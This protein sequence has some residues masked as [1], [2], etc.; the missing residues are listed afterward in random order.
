MS[1]A[2]CVDLGF[3]TSYPDYQKEF[4]NKRPSA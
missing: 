1:F 3:K 2:A 4:D